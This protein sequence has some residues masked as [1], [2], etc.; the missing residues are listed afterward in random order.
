MPT[1]PVCDKPIDLKD[2]KHTPFL[3]FC[4]ERCRAIDLGR[5]FGE[6]YSV[7]V[8]TRRLAEELLEDVARDAE[9]PE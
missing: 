6:G 2:P 5:W 1:C 7:P 3:P 8:E 9:E 4:G